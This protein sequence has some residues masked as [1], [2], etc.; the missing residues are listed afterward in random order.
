MSARVLCVHKDTDELLRIKGTLQSAGYEVVSANS[1]KAALN[2]LLNERFD[3]VVLDSKIA[4]S[5]G[6]SLRYQIQ[7]VSPG[8]PCLM[9]SDERELG[10]LP[11]WVFREYLDDPEPPSN[12]LLRK[13]HA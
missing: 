10:S 7:H 4:T 11:L 12:V 9:Y 6:T 5:S 1:G 3:G 13:T 8:V 2:V